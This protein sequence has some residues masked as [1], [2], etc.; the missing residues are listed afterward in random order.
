MANYTSDLISVP[1]ADGPA[2]DRVERL[3]LDGQFVGDWDAHIVTYP[4]GGGRHQGP[5]GP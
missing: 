3:G 2:F 5:H 4:P 1:H